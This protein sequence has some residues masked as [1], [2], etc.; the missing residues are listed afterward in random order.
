LTK[1]NPILISIID[2]KSEMMKSWNESC[3]VFFEGNIENFKEKFIDKMVYLDSRRVYHDK[4]YIA[5][6]NK[7]FAPEIKRCRLP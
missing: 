1:S 7:I 3:L 4:Y 6:W 2:Y 5:F